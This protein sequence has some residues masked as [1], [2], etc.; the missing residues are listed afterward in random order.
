[1]SA[2]EFRD[3]KK[4]HVILTKSEANY[5]AEDD[6]YNKNVRKSLAHGV[7][8]PVTTDMKDTLTW[9][10]GRDAVERARERQTVRHL[11]PIDGSKKRG[12]SGGVK[13]TKATRGET[14]KPAPPVTYGD[15]FK[16]RRFA[17]I[18]RYAIDD[19]GPGRA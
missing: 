4:S 2:R 13:L 5:D 8:T 18:G 1:V 17:D 9:Q 3:F 14:V 11:P 15:T 16:L 6:E 19:F 7:P 12:L 10:F